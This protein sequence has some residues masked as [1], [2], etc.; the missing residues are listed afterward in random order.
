MATTTYEKKEYVESDA[1]RQ[2]KAALEAQQAM[3]PGA[4]QSQWQQ[5]LNDIIGKIQNRD[6][7]TY[8]L[9]GDALYQQY[10]DRYIQQ[11]QQAMMDT[12]GQA[13]AL[14]GGYGNS[15]AQTVGQQTYQGYLQGLNDKVPELYQLAMNKYQ[16]EGDELYNQFGLLSTQENQ[17]YGRYRD[18]VGDWNTALDRFQNQYNAER[19]FDYG[20]YSD[21]RNFDYGQYVD[22]RNYQYQVD[23]DAVAD[24]QWNQSFEYQQGRDQ[25]ADEQWQKEFEEAQRQYNESLAKSSGGSS[26]GGGSKAT[27]TTNTSTYNNGSLSTAKIMEMQGF[28][29]V[30]ADGKWGSASSKAAGGRD[31]DAAWEYY[32][33]ASGQKKQQT[34]QSATYTLSELANSFA[35]GATKAQVESALKA[36]GVNI[37]DP[38]VQADIKWAMSK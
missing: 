23:R 29:G 30:E 13:A 20:K 14:T 10:K 24:S 22:D 12:M 37:N 11:G 1:V 31:A 7:F 38:A 21:D 28:F 5:S 6:K 4:Y 34:T 35:G 19:E 15:Y 17:D 32:L 18:Q 26:G 9:N 2:A 8:D 16:M 27:T 33:E 3:Q 36:R 25:I